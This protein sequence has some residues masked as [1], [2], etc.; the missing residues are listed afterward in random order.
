MGRVVFRAKLNV[1]LTVIER[2]I[3]RLLGI[4]LH[5][6]E[7][8]WDIVSRVSGRRLLEEIVLFALLDV[9]N[10]YADVSVEIME[11]NAIR[12]F[13]ISLIPIGSGLDV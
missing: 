8:V 10:I 11:E 2:I 4:V 7:L 5:G 13:I 6:S 12:G 3:L 1:G 9:C